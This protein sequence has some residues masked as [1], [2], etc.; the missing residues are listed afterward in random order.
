MTQITEY[1][2]PEL[3]ILVPVLY[4]IGMIIHKTEK[5]DNK[6]IPIILG[7]VGILLSALWVVATASLT[8]PSEIA[9][10]IFTAIVQGIIV[11]GVAVYANQIKKQ[12]TN[13]SSQG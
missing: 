6:F 10:A 13:N 7:I 12:A 9:M 1:V 11:A 3:L 4:I 2:Q 5:I 8:T